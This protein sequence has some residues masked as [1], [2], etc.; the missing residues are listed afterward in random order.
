[1]AVF[2]RKESKYRNRKVR[3]DGYVFDSKKESERYLQLCAMQ[4]QGLIR[5]LS[6]HP[7]FQ[8]SV[9][10]EPVCSYQADFSYLKV[11]NGEKFDFVVEDVKSKATKTDVYRLKKKLMKAVLGIEV[12]EYE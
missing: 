9:N 12:K 10:N 4:R 7:R 11:K 3:L 1:M 6:V 2:L 8:I 5:E